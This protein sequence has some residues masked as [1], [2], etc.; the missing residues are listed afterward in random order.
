MAVTLTSVTGVDL[1]SG[2]DPLSAQMSPFPTAVNAATTN[3]CGSMNQ[4]FNNVTWVN[5]TPAMG[6][7]VVI[8][9]STPADN[10]NKI[11]LQADDTGG[12]GY[13]WIAT[14]P[15]CCTPAIGATVGVMVKNEG[16]DEVLFTWI[17]SENTSGFSPPG[18]GV[19]MPGD[20]ITFFPTIP[21]CTPGFTPL[22]TCFDVAATESPTILL[23]R[24]GV[25]PLAPL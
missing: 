20:T 13:Q 23:T 6:G 5:D 14:V 4:D 10:T 11:Q 2:P 24:I 15:F 16:P 3:C 22:M 12:G 17:Y 25:E 18:G 7:T 1:P 19:I 21:T 8:T 9:P